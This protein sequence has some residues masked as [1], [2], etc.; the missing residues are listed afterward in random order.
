MRRLTILL[1]SLLCL[2]RHEFRAAG[3]W[4]KN[5]YSGKAW[6]VQL[7]L[8]VGWALHTMWK[9][10]PDA[11]AW[12]QFDEPV[13]RTPLW[14]RDKNPL[15]NY[16][17][18]ENAQARFPTEAEVVVIGAGFV[19]AGAAYHW[20]QH[21]R[22]RMVV[23]EMNEAAS[24]AGGRNAGVVT[25]GRYYHFVHSTVL[26]NL[27]ETRPDLSEAERIA[28]AHQHAQPYVLAG[29]KSAQLIEDTVKKEKID[30][31]Y[32]KRGWVWASD[33]KSKDKPAAAQRMGEEVGQTDWIRISSTEAMEFGGV[34]TPYDAGYSRGTASWHPAKWIWGLLQVA[35]KSSHVEFY[36]RTKVTAVRDAGEHYEV[37]TQRGMIR[38][39]NVINATESHTALLFKEFHNINIVDQSQAAWGP[40]DAGTMKEAVALSAPAMFYTHAQR[41]VLF[42]SDMSPVA[43]H[44]AGRNKPSRFITNYVAGSLRQ[45]FGIRK[46]RV[47]NE[48]SG[49]VGMTPDEFPLIG[50]QD[51]KRLYMVGGLAG[52]GSG[53]SFLAT[54]FVV[55][56]ILDIDCP[57]YYPEEY[58]SPRRFFKS[59]TAGP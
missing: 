35:L 20:S 58:F 52:S 54:Q 16:P 41:G 49:T 22:S 13:S 23:L 38:A 10:I 1:W 56:K 9:T 47:T 2:R 15:E 29:E 34:K 7:F 5:N 17:W 19:G 4:M 24:G 40:S 59:E 53:V 21:G 42:G 51:N 50:L 57:D 36:S 14:L 3:T 8:F 28:I 26:K 6:P 33:E 44:H 30:C 39:R 12:V 32:V 46:L 55:F 43:D 31:N 48:W 11:L 45:Y 27:Q 25:R 37:H 18:Q